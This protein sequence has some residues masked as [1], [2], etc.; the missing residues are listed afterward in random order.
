MG[1]SLD[2]NESLGNERFSLLKTSNGALFMLAL[3]V[4]LIAISVIDI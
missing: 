4:E 1:D 3:I 2:N